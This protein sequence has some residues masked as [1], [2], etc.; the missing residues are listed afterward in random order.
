[1]TKPYSPQA[2]PLVQLDPSAYPCPEI[3][4]IAALKLLIALD[5]NHCDYT[6]DNDGIVQ[7]CSVA[8]YGE[9]EINLIYA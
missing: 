5:Q 1:M 3:Y 6:K 7:N 9:H 8:Y 2:C 4:E